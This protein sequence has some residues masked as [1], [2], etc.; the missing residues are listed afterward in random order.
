M[1][2]LALASVAVTSVSLLSCAWAAGP[3]AEAIDLRGHPQTLRVY[4]PARGPVAIVASGDG[5]WLHLGP[6]VAEFLAGRGFVVLGFDS[7]GYLSS[8]TTRAGTL[9][10]TDVPGDFVS[11]LDRAMQTGTGAPVLV[12]VSEGAALAVLAATQKNVKA[13][14]LGVIGL[15]L[16]DKA[17]LGWRFR[18]SIIYITKGVPDEPTFSTAEIV[19]Q[20]A[21]LPLVAIHSTRDEFVPVEEIQRVMSRAREPKQLWILPASNHR[22]SDSQPGLQQKLLDAIEWMK[23]QRR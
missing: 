5:G 12:G 21:P 3:R 17:E 8:F 16:P 10:P 4:G 6:D 15:G 13:K 19:D 14:A 2:R 18:D 1:K 22:F 11:L 7:K 9:S 20:V 23:A